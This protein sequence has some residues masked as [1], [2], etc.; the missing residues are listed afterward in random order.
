MGV[1]SDMFI[2]EI[3][4]LVATFNAIPGNTA[5]AV[6]AL[7]AGGLIALNDPFTGPL[8]EEE[9]RLRRFLKQG[10][11]YTGL[12]GLGR[13]GRVVNVSQLAHTMS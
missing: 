4:A 5:A 6:G 9:R 8:T 1:G 13:K 10:R 3:A 11:Q 7:S 2:L 12:P